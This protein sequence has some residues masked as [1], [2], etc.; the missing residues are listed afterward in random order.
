MDIYRIT[1]QFPR[2]EMFG[3]THQI[4]KAAFSI[5]ANMVE[6]SFRASLPEY[7][8]FLNISLGSAGEVGYYIHFAEKL[9]YLAAEDAALL[10]RKHEDCTRSLQALIAALQ[11]RR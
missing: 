2:E 1:R 3:L 8:N 4:R 6:G 10:A 11:K 9:E 5:P 7:L